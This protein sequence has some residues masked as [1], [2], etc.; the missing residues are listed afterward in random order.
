M[1]E[2]PARSRTVGEIAAE[3]AIPPHRVAHVTATR[4]IVPARRSGIV[5]LFAPPAVQRIGRK[6]ASMKAPCRK[7]SRPTGGQVTNARGPAK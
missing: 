7:Q 6:L 3:R 5:R 2:R 1:H 4:A